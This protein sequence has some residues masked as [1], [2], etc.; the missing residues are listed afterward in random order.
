M[1]RGEG[2]GGG[3]G[4]VWGNENKSSLLP[5]TQLSPALPPAGHT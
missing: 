4:G 2:E 1:G 5:Q 3:G